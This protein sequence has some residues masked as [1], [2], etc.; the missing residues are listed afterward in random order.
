MRGSL[1]WSLVAVLAAAIGCTRPNPAFLIEGDE[2]AANGGGNSGGSGGARGEVPGP[3]QGTPGTGGSGA[4]GGNGT[5]G[6][7]G[8]GGSGGA[9]APDAGPVSP[10]GQAALDTLPPDAPAVDLR[11][12]DAAMVDAPRDATPD[13]TLNPDLA[14]LP[15]GNGLMVELWDG[16]QL[17]MGTGSGHDRDWTNQMINFDWGTGT[18]T[19]DNTFDHDNFS[20]RFRGQ[21]LPAYT[22]SYTFISESDEGVRLWIDDIKVFDSWTGS[23]FTTTMGRITL[24]GR[25]KHKFLMEYRESTGNASVKL[26][27][28]SPSLG[29]KQ[30]VPKAALFYP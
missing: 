11:P 28:S 21:I 13:V 17:E 6:G 5:G 1:A 3:D 2:S 30:I 26:F 15:A 14:P 27:W 12:A 9:T 16:T 24:T 10:D 18:P 29:A 20:M 19:G 25:V 23:G 8:A 7:S 4:T 22:E